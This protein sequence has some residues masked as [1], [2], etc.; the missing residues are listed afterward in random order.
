MRLSVNKKVLSVGAVVD[1]GRRYFRNRKQSI[2]IINIFFEEVLKLLIAGHQV[3]FPR[4]GNGRMFLADVKTKSNGM[5]V[6]EYIKSENA[7]NIFHGVVKP[8]LKGFDVKTGGKVADDKK[9]GLRFSYPRSTIVMLKQEFSE[10]E[11]RRKLIEID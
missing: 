10:D 9:F 11:K 1:K 8:M 6:M 7:G 4:K 5:K 3:R 2:K